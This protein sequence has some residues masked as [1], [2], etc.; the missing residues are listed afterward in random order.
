MFTTVLCL[1]QRDETRELIHPRD[2]LVRLYDNSIIE[3]FFFSVAFFAL[4]D[5]LCTRAKRRNAPND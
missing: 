1:S 5:D 4:S 3:F 2:F